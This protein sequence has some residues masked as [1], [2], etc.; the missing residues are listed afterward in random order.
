MS[1]SVHNVMTYGE[2]GYLYVLLD[3]P[4]VGSIIYITSHELFFLISNFRCVLSVV[5][6]V[7]GY[8]RRLNFVCSHLGTLCLFNLLYSFFWV[9][10]R[11]LN[12]MCRRFGTLSLF[13]LHRRCK[14]L[15]PPMK[16]E[17]IVPKRRHVKFRRWGITQKKV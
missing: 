16:M 17:Q 4:H 5:F 8:A 2:S 13:H 3:P 1:D 11:L 7:L 9:I 14:L 15:A 6:F 10:P 12:L